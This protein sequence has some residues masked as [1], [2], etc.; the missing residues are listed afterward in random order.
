[1][2]SV[3]FISRHTAADD[4]VDRLRAQ[5]QSVRFCS[6]LVSVTHTMRR[7]LQCVMSLL[8]LVEVFLLKLFVAL[9]CSAVSCSLWR[10]PAQRARSWLCSVFTEDIC[11]RFLGTRIPSP[12]SSASRSWLCSPSPRPTPRSVSRR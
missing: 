7:Y 3:T 12:L 9:C 5:R 2:L 4:G 8:Q 6:V 10:G 11:C 1:M